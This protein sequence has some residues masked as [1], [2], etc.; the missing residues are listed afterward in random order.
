[1]IMNHANPAVTPVLAHV[2]FPNQT[3]ARH[4]VTDASPEINKQRKG[5]AS[6]VIVST[7]FKLLDRMSLTV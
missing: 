4:P 7:N 3:A 2:L 1:M 6:S 5:I